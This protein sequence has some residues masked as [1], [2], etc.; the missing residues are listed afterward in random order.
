M[1]AERQLSPRTVRSICSRAAIPHQ[2]VRVRG[3]LG[4]HR[5]S[6]RFPG[7]RGTNHFT[8]VALEAISI[9][10]R[11]APAAADDEDPR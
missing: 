4:R 9:Q 6:P 10:A 7:Y 1:P 3:I 2:C 5:A 8:D 11:A